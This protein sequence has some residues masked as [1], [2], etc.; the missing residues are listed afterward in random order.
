MFCRFNQ[1]LFLGTSSSDL[2]AVENV[3]SMVAER[4]ARHY[5]P[6]ATVDELLCLAKACPT[7]SVP[8]LL[9][10]EIIAL[11]TDFSGSMLP[12]FLKK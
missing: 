9:L 1:F 5:T 8:L 11:S 10:P 6:E 3:W 7:V 2:S 12:N 4:L